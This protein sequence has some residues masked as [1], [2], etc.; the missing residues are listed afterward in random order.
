MEQVRSFVAI[1]LSD[2]VKESLGQVQALLKRKEI[3]DLV[4]WVRPEGMHI[5]LKFLGNV[6]VN[7]IGEITVG[8]DQASK[9]IARFGLSFEGLGCFPSARR[10]NV[11]WVGL[12]G[13]TRTLAL[14]RQRIEDNMA[15][16]GFPPEKRNFTPH[17]TLGRVGRRVG[18]NERGRLGGLIDMQTLDTVGQIQVQEVSLIRSVLSPAGAKY[19]R[20]AV[21]QLEAE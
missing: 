16:L 10:P 5:T 2:E 7:R 12:L 18:S 9:G 6:P 15:T 14:L 1:E 4:R 3:A 8:L 19:S 17:L 21:V 11:I 20:L 13:D